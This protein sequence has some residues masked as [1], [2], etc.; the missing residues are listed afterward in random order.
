MNNRIVTTLQIGLISF[1]MFADQNLM[2]PNLT[3]IAEDFG[4]VDVKDQYLGGLIPLVF[5]L[6]GGI[7]ALLIAMTAPNMKAILM[8]VNSPYSR[9]TVFSLYN[10][11]DDLGRGFGPLIIGNILIYQFGRNI[12]FNIANVFWFVCGCLILMMIR[13]FPKEDRGK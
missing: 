3:L 6:L 13:S 11:A 7:V 2:G 1:F 8:N 10:F 4:L 9:G 12:A 5:W